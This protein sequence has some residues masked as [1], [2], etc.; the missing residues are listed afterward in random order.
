MDDLALFFH[1]IGSLL[2]VSGI[3]L[4]GVGFETAR[5]R[6]RPD[7]VALLLGVA[8]I[9]VLL[10]AI[11]GVLLPAFGLWLVHL[12]HFGY[13]SG[14][15]DASIALYMAALA[16]GGLGGRRPRQARKLATRLAREHATVNGEL[17]ALLD[18]RPSRAANY[19]AALIVLAILVLMVFK[20]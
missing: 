1:L 19:V 6:T 17:R 5:R 11:G 8:R 18:D 9:G 2:F 10:V 20:P 15:V 14:W 7:D 3:V 13:R 16:L 4:V 12:G